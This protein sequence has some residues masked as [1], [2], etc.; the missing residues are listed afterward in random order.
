MSSP[1]GTKVSN[2]ATN[3]V[4]VAVPGAVGSPVMEPGAGRAPAVNST[5][6]AA[7]RSAT[8]VIADCIA[9]KTNRVSSVVAPVHLSLSS[10]GGSVGMVNEPTDW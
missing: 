4:S 3:A 8:S 6:S 5:V 9:F 10:A 2:A 7:M 1:A